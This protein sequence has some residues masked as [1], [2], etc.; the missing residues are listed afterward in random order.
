MTQEY[1]SLKETN[2]FKNTPMGF[3]MTFENGYTISVQWGPGN[4][5]ATRNNEEFIKQNPFTGEHRT[6][7][8]HTAE[9]AAWGP[10]GEWLHLSEHDDVA[11]WLTA[12]KVAEY[13]AVLSGSSPKQAEW[14][15]WDEG[16]SQSVKHS[17]VSHGL[18]Y[19]I[20]KRCYVL[21]RRVFS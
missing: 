20:A 7:E 10:D 16:Q 15:S 6:Y 2:G 5:C 11:G 4:Y 14:L 12:D 8:S 13:I 18:F 1:K 21:S 3:A 17:T 19:K 9:I